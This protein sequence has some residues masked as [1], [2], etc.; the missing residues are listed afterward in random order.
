MVGIYK[1]TSPSGRVYIGQ[2][3]NIFNRFKSYRRPSAVKD[4]PLLKHSFSKYG[5]LAHKFGI[6]SSLP[7]DI[8]QAQLNDYERLYIECYRAAGFRMLNIREGGS[9]GRLNPESIAKMRASL[10]GKKAWN[11]GLKGVIV[12]SEETRKKISAA[13][14]GKQY[15]LGSKRPQSAIDATAQKNTGK[16]R[17]P[18]QIDR[19]RKSVTGKNLNNKNA[20][21]SVRTEANRKAISDS[22]K[23]RSD[24]K[25]EMSPR[26]KLTAAQVIEIRRKYIPRKYSSYKLASEFGVSRVAINHI[27]RGKNWSTV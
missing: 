12:A 6:E 19:I 2:S 15:S 1:I 24:N 17:T 20:Y 7:F 22:L 21:G 5:V 14:K 16:T 13:N 26:S 11:K 9:N 27:I 25:G 10:A 18:V 8:K 4:Q 3:W 23:R